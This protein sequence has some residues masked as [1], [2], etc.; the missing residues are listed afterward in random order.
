MS[1]D[2]NGE[3]QLTFSFVGGVPGTNPDDVLSI[4]E[5]NARVGKGVEDAI[6]VIRRLVKEEQL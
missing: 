5:L 1:Y 4:T 2:P 6:E 3:M